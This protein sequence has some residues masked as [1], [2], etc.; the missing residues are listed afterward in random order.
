LNRLRP[1]A[2]LEGLE[3]AGW[4][5]ALTTNPSTMHLAHEADDKDLDVRYSLGFY[6]DDEG[7][8]IGD[9][10]PHSPADLAGASPGSHLIALDGYKWSKDLLHDTLAAPAEPQRRLSFLIE[11]DSRFKTLEVEYAGG[12]RYPNLVRS[13]AGPDLLEQIARPRAADHD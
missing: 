9:I 2:P 8:T 13:A 5:L 1:G 6:V 7:A 4:H 3:A 11:K 12:E 10:I